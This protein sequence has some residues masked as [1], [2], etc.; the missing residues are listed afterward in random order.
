MPGWEFSFNLDKVK[1]KQQQFMNHISFMGYLKDT[2]LLLILLKLELCCSVSTR[3]IVL[4]RHICQ[5][6]IV[7]YFNMLAL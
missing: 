1:V 7:V 2:C 4:A 3:V 6:L 5:S